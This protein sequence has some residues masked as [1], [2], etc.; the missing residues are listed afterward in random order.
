MTSSGS[1]GDLATVLAR[2][3]LPADN[4]LA[5]QAAL[6]APLRD[7]H[8]LVLAG[9]AATGAPPAPA[10]LDAW[11]SVHG[12]DLRHALRELGD[13]ELVFTDADATAVTGAVPFAAGVSAHRVAIAGGP[14]AFANCA[15]DALGIAA[16]LDRD[17]TITSTDPGSGEPVTATSRAGR[18]SWQPPDAVVFVGSRGTGPITQCCCPVI[19]FFT[20]VAHATGYQQQHGL[21]GVVLGMAQAARAGALIFGG[22]LR[23]PA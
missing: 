22:L 1:D 12:V 6:P 13:T 23:D 15:V 16:M 18:W 4:L 14:Q 21:S 5:R 7:L 2:A 11:A 8:R 20:S 3:G 19:N 9:F 17:I 10:D